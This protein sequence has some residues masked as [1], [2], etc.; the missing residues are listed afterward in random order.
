MLSEPQAG[1][2]AASRSASQRIAC[3]VLSPHISREGF[4]PPQNAGRSDRP[5]MRHRM[6]SSS[7]TQGTPAG[8]PFGM[9]GIGLVID[10]AMQQAPQPDL[11]E[12]SGALASVEGAGVV[13]SMAGLSS[14]VARRRQPA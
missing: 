10:G 5:K 12:T 8:L 2:V 7:C 13:C 1:R 6:S 9:P 4:S 11:Q 14:R 3:G